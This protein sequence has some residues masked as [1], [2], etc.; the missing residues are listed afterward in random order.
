[1]LG[2]RSGQV[3]GSLTEAGKQQKRLYRNLSGLRKPSGKPCAPRC[4]LVCAPKSPPI[5]GF[6]VKREVMSYKKESFIKGVAPYVK[7]WEET[8]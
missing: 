4:F 6:Q 2:A 5:K 3:K 1:M 8:R 7:K